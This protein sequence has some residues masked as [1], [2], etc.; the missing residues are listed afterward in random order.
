[1]ANDWVNHVKHYAATHGITYGEALKKAKASYTKSPRKMKGGQTL[2]DWGLQQYND[3]VPDAYR[4]G[5]ESLGSAAFK[6]MGFGLKKRK[7]RKMKGG[8]TLKDWGLQQYNDYVPDAYRPGVESLGNAAFKQMGFGIFDD[9]GRAFQPVRDAI[10]PVRNIGR[11]LIQREVDT[12]KAIASDPRTKALAKQVAKQILQTGVDSAG[13]AAAAAAAAS[14]NPE[15]AP[16]AAFLGR[17]LALQA[18]PYGDSYIDGLGLRKRRTRKGRALA[19]A[20][21]Y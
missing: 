15:L 17:Q 14:G 9:I 19:P 8:Q 12:A 18:Q 6:Q 4:P 16:A 2:K 5:V 3:Y 1:M 7:P 13:P 20:G 21:Y 11:R 10:R